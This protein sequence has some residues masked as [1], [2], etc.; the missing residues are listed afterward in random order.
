LRNRSLC[1]VAAFRHTFQITVFFRSSHNALSGAGISPKPN[2]ASA[3]FDCAV[4]NMVLLR[5]FVGW[6]HDIANLAKR[7]LELV[8]TFILQRNALK[9]RRRG[10]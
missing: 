10:C 7:L 3:I 2:M 6:Q 1:D 4:G 5:G 9:V 8:Y